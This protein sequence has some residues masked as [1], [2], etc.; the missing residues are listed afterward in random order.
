MWPWGFVWVCKRICATVVKSANRVDLSPLFSAFF[1]CFPHC[2][3][4]RFQTERKE[5]VV[6]VW[7]ESFLVDASHLFLWTH[8][9]NFFF[10]LLSIVVLIDV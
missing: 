1:Q 2:C 10:F 7:I 5:L 6:F 9:F 8:D 4:F 3:R